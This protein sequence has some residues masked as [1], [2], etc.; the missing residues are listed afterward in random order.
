[1]RLLLVLS[2]VLL[3]AGCGVQVTEVTPDLITAAQAR[4]PTTTPAELAKG[5]ELFTTTCVSCH[6]QRDPHGHTVKEWEF[7][8]SQMAPKVPLDNASA[9]AVL[10][11]VV[12]ASELPVAP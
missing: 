4:Y 10:R 7:Y 2:G 3:L 9:Q 6:G 5:R 11:F 8:V 12:T 1:M